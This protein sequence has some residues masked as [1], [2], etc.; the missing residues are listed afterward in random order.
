[1]V[2]LLELLGIPYLVDFSRENEVQTVFF[3]VHWLS[4]DKMGY[5]FCNETE[6]DR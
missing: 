6:D 3:R 5:F 2:N 4:E 1:M